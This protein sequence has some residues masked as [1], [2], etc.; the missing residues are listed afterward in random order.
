MLVFFCPVFTLFGSDALAKKWL[1]GISPKKA[2]FLNEVQNK[3]TGSS[4]YALQ[5]DLIRSNQLF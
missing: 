3:W 1:H 2:K 5:H 4:K